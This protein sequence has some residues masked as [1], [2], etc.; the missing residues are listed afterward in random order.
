MFPSTELSKPKDSSATNVAKCGSQ[1]IGSMFTNDLTKR[2]KLE[3]FRAITVIGNFQPKNYKSL[4]PFEYMWRTKKQKPKSVNIVPEHL[5]HAKK[6]L[7][8]FEAYTWKIQYGEK[9]HSVNYVK[10]GSVI[11]IR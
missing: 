2:K 5:R 9:K 8:T 7:L 4:I 1:N 3:I 6:F 11:D 10:L